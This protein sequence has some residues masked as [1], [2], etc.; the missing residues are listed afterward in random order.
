MKREVS[1]SLVSML[2]GAVFSQRA[3]AADVLHW[4]VDGAEREALVSAPAHKSKSNEPLLFVFHGHGGN[5]HLAERG[6]AFHE[7]WPEAVVVYPQGLPS[8][9]YLHDEQGRL[10]GWQHEAGENGDRDL[11]FVDAMIATLRRTY[12]IDENRVYATGFSNGG[13]F[14][15]L[16]W[17]E[18]PDVFAAVAPGA[19]LLVPSLHLHTAKPAFIYGGENDR[20]VRF[21]SQEAAMTAAREANGC[22][23]VGKTCG[24]DCTVFASTQGAPV[25]TYVHPAGHVFVPAVRPMIVRFFEDHPREE[26]PQ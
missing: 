25:M 19:A 10:A 22:V 16:L 5:M 9:G 12:S 18:R 13:F 2:I 24:D 23:R 26:R 14:C 7:R 11:K 15:Y 8:R 17:A 20:L 1:I 21:A 3:S 6:Q 4:N